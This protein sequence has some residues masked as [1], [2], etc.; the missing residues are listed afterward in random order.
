MNF[1]KK[2][3]QFIKMVNIIDQY[4]SFD[5]KDKILDYEGLRACHVI[6]VGLNKHIVYNCEILHIPALKWSSIRILYQNG[7]VVSAHLID[8]NQLPSRYN[9]DPSFS[10]LEPNTE[11]AVLIRDRHGDFAIIKSSWEGKINGKKNLVGQIGYLAVTICNIKTRI[12]T[13]FNVNVINGQFFEFKLSDIKA[14]VDL[15]NGH[16]SLQ[17]LK[18]VEN[19]EIERILCFTIS[20]SLLHVLLQPKIPLIKNDLNKKL[21]EEIVPIY[22]GKKSVK[23]INIKRFML[24]D[25]IGYAQLIE[26]NL[27]YNIISEKKRSYFN[28]WISMN[29]VKIGNTNFGR[30]NYNGYNCDADGNNGGDFE[31]ENDCGGCGGCGGGGCDGGG[32]GG[33]GC[34]G[35]ACGG[36]GCDGGGC[37][38]GGCGCD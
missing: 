33:G 9:V 17:L 35:G 8:S 16:V 18:P 38:G 4:K 26:S 10:S 13:M 7:C 2:D 25:M 14:K 15:V 12:M 30:W 21:D 3:F 37:D 28:N 6:T 36:G 27:I 22:R 20:I 31:D 24:L 29:F 1:L 5:L 23:T 32:C 34:D 11:K 19:V